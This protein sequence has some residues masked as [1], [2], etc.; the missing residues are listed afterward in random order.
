MAISFKF[1][2]ST[3]PGNPVAEAFFSSLSQLSEEALSKVGKTILELGDEVGGFLHAVLQS[4]DL[5]QG[6]K[7]Q[8]K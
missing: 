8:L 4:S 1:T 5:T 6:I 3:K 2:A 7:N